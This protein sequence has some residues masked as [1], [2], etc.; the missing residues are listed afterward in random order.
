V[1]TDLHHLPQL[2]K[3]EEVVEEHLLQVQTQPIQLQAQEVMVYSTLLGQD[4]DCSL[5]RYSGLLLHRLQV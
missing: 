3:L 2:D 5:R 1:E 4:L